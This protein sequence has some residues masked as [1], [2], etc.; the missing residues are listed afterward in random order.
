MTNSFAANIYVEPHGEAILLDD[1]RYFNYRSIQARLVTE[2]A[3]GRLKIRFRVLFRKCESNKE[4]VKLYGL[5]YVVLYN[6]CIERGDLVPRKLCL[7]LDHASN[8]CLSPEEVK[9]ALALRSTNQ[10]NFQINKKSQA[11]QVQ[12]A[13]TA[14]M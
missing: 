7:A 1:K 12:K 11:L 9:D 8:K 10:K 6:L 2:G 3:F 5:A 14:K 4:I 13:L